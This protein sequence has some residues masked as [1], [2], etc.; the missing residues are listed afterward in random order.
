MF[1]YFK[2]LFVFAKKNCLDNIKKF[3]ERERE[4]I[5]FEFKKE[6]VIIEYLCIHFK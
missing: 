1:K 4:V 5:Y 3:I 6:R 2:K